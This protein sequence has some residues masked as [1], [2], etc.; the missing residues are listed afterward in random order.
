MDEAA[1]RH[2]AVNERQAQ[3]QHQGQETSVAKLGEIG[4]AAAAAAII[5][6]GGKEE[7]PNR[8]DDEVPR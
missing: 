8:R 7:S 1:V 5:R 6:Q 2:T 3:M 4:W